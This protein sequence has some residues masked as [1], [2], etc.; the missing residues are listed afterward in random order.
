MAAFCQRF[1]TTNGKQC[2]G[3]CG[4]VHIRLRVKICTPTHQ[5]RLCRNG[6]DCPFSHFLPV[7][8]YCYYNI[9]Y[10]GCRYKNCK[11]IHLN[12]QTIIHNLMNVNMIKFTNIFFKCIKNFYSNDII[13]PYLIGLNNFCKK[14]KISENKSKF[15]TNA[16]CILCDTQADSKHR[17][18]DGLIAF[19]NYKVLPKEVIVSNIAKFLIS[20]IKHKRCIYIRP[21]FSCNN[22]YKIYEKRQIIRQINGVNEIVYR[23]IRKYGTLN[24]FKD[25]IEE[26][27]RNLEQCGIKPIFIAAILDRIQ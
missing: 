9:L 12:R 20:T 26:S 3:D 6:V 19:I 16:K 14:M 7:S 4:L 11:H 25:N 22:V 10:D 1:Y 2:S 8:K 5:N 18:S 27:Y 24:I 15:R 13:T 23:A 17:N 21:R